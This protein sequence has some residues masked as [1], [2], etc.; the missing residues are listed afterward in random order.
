MHPLRF[1][2][3]VGEGALAGVPPN[4]SAMQSASTG[5]WGPACS[6]VPTHF[7]DGVLL[8]ILPVGILLLVIFSLLLAVE[9]VHGHHEQDLTLPVC[10]E[11]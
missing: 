5:L 7:E 2:C 4:F 3:L 10:N 6:A 11:T 1:A 8:E 9:P